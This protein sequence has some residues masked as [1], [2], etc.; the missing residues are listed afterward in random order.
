MGR[1]IFKPGEIRVLDNKVFINPP[2]IPLKQKV[3]EGV[4]EE[5]QEVVEEL[6][7]TPFEEE[8]TYSLEEEREK[9]YDEAKKVKEEADSEARRIREEAESEALNLNRERESELQRLKEVAQEE[10]KRIVEEATKKAQEIENSSK[11]KAEKLLIEIKIKA[12]EEGEEEGFKKGE[13]EVKRL[14]ERLHII[15]NA[16]IDLRKEI[17]E[18]T[19]KQLIDLVF[20]ITKKVVKII[21]ESEKK[22]V[23]E[24]VKEAL[25]KVG[26][27]TSIT[28][29]VN[30]QD[31]E[32]T[33]KHKGKFIGLIEG[34][35]TVTILED[36]RVDPGGCII[37]TSFG[38]VDARIQRQLNIIE[39]KIRELS[40]LQG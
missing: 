9:L 14:I 26:K 30:T 7:A 40:P 12:T 3:E 6:R 29:R 35:E 32:L 13:E 18:R 11:E 1:K 5:V 31:L 39:E 22:V 37:E 21:S 38:D 10:A 34:V 4:V 25:K 15:L 33:T 24:N 36:S 8:K 27:E 17:V 19:E 23:I 20:L 28:I 2:Y 16:A